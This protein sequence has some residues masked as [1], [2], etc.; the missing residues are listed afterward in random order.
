MCIFITNKL[1]TCFD[2]MKNK[3]PAGK[4]HEICKLRINTV[5]ISVSLD[6]RFTQN[7]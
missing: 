1:A 5:R 2:D 3:S 6:S 7:V 4:S